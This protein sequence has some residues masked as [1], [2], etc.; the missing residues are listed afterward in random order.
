MIGGKRWLNRK[1]PIAIIPVANH[2][3]AQPLLRQASNAKHGALVDSNLVEVP[4]NLQQLQNEE[5][6]TQFLRLGR[7]GTN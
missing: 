4:G 3:M 6:L 1:R 2:R 5:P 7:K